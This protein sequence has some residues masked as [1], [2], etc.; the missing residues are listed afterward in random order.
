MSDHLATASLLIHCTTAPYGNSRARDAIDTAL[1]GAVFDQNIQLLFSGD[2]VLQLLNNQNGSAIAQKNIQSLLSV[3]SI[4][5]ID[6]IYVQQ[7]ALQQR[8]ISAQSLTLET[9]VLSE[10]EVGQLLDRQQHIFSF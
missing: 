10:Q 5:G 2:G 8:G 3:L 1:A 9:T 7:S 4:Y 6:T